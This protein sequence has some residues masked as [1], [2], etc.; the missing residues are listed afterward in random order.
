MSFYAN[1]FRVYVDL[2]DVFVLES[3]SQIC[4][5]EV[6]FILHRLH[7]VP[8]HEQCPVSLSSLNVLFG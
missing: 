5:S 6:T 3:K 2:R 1:M 7:P 8:T 4:S